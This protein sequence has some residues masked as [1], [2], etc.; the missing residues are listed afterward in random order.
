MD[1]VQP[2]YQE[3]NPVVIPGEDEQSYNMITGLLQVLVHLQSP[4]IKKRPANIF[5][6]NRGGQYC[7]PSVRHISCSMI[8]QPLTP[9]TDIS[10]PNGV[11][12]FD[13]LR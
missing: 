5:I 6:Q 7:L 3:G 1:V 2:V 9:L 13:H 11:S 10:S 4:Q 8:L 12:N